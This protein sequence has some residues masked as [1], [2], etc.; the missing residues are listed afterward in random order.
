MDG[1]MAAK[2]ESAVMWVE[3]VCMKMLVLKQNISYHCETTVGR[4]VTQL[5]HTYFNFY[6]ST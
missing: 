3:S 4:D 2:K 1:W 6:H 5:D